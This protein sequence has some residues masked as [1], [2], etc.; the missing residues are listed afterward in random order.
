MGLRLSG[1][2]V[3]PLPELSYFVATDSLEDGGMSSAFE[4]PGTRFLLDGG[5]V[6]R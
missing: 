1:W 2:A 4:D 3:V 6:A 5:G